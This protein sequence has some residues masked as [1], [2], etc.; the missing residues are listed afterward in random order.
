MDRRKYII[1][2]STILVFII[3]IAIILLKNKTV[4]WQKEVLEADNYTITMTDCNNRTTQF[5]NDLTKEIFTKLNVTSNNGPWTGDN[6]TCYSKLIIS[7]EKN[8]SLK[9]IEISIIDE[10]SIM[11]NINNDTRYYTNAEDIVRYLNNL[12]QTY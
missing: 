3:I 10:S 11:I 4:E 7:Y 2:G 8:N 9:N 6:N 5:P 1:I 12:F